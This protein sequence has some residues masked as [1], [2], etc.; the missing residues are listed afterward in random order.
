MSNIRV[1]QRL[2]QLKS[3]KNIESMNLHDKQSFMN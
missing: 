3:K 1:K 2:E